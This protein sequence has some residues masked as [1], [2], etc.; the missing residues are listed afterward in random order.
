M[1]E[2]Y[3]FSKRQIIGGGEGRSNEL[4][5]SEGGRRAWWARGIMGDGVGGNSGEDG[6]GERGECRTGK[7]NSASRVGSSSRRT[8]SSS[9]IEWYCRIEISP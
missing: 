5:G 9:P 2:E 1:F 4:G 7:E 6:R 3:E 8:T